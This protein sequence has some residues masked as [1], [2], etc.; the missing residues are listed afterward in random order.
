LMSL[1]FPADRSDGADPLLSSGKVG[2]GDLVYVTYMKDSLVRFGL[3]HAGQTFESQPVFAD[4][5]V[6]HSITVVSNALSPS[7]GKPL[8]FEILCDS[9]PVI[10]LMLQTYESAPE[11]IYVGIDSVELGASGPMFSGTVVSALGFAPPERSTEGMPATAFPS[12]RVVL[13]ALFDDT[14]TKMGEPVLVVGETGKADF[15]YIVRSDSTHMQIGLDHWSVGG[16]LSAPFE[17]D[18]KIWHTIQIDLGSLRLGV[19]DQRGRDREYRIEFDGKLVLAGSANLYPA[20]D[21]NVYVGMNPLGGSTA[22]YRFHGHIA[23]RGTDRSR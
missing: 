9:K 23:V 19:G 13:E 2:R 1:R 18:P 16:P 4:R 22:G 21:Q 6:I 20:T 15:V 17:F 3:E 10:R 8:P 5:A 12:G 7:D 11:D 14:L